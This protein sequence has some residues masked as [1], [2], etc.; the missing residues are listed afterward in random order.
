MD[1][2]GNL[3]ESLEEGRRGNVKL[4]RKLRDEGGR[5]WM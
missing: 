1:L 2:G 4:R 5:R 3:N